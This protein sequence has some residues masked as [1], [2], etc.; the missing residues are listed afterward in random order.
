MK[1]VL[2]FLGSGVSLASGMPDVET[3]T[4]SVFNK[5]MRYGNDRYTEDAACAVYGEPDPPEVATVRSLI[6]KVQSVA[7]TY[8]DQ[9]TWDREVNYEDLFYICRQI[10]QCEK[11]ES[12]S[13]APLVAEIKESDEVDLLDAPSQDDR[14]D[15]QYT[16]LH[17]QLLIRGV[18]QTE[19]DD[20]QREVKGLDVIR[21]VIEDPEVRKTT[22]VTL[23]HDRLVERMLEGN[24]PDRWTCDYADG[25]GN[26]KGLAREYEAGNIF[27]SEESV[28]VIKP[29][30]SVDWF[31]AQKVF[32]DSDYQRLP[33]T[34]IKH[35]NPTKK[36]IRKLSN[37]QGTTFEITAPGPTFLTG[38]GKEQSYGADI[39]GDMI[40][41]MNAGLE[42]ADL[43]LVSG[44]GWKD[45][46]MSHRL[47]NA[48]EWNRERRMIL[49][50]SRDALRSDLLC[51]RA[52]Y[53][54]GTGKQYRRLYR[55]NQITTKIESFLSGTGWKE[56][57]QAVE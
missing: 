45:Q 51:N 32:G 41:A 21:Q 14:S 1:H 55:R 15:L 53:L 33:L 12:P 7:E 38:F 46:G 37:G 29:H 49:L 19:L 50:Y 25:F 44:F 30:G 5:P 27:N 13:I 17:A 3:L 11:G 18:V 16:A 48:L 28:R 23:N 52:S 34:Y 54:F 31:W 9:F 35:S 20:E 24:N 4:A 26:A 39:F 8:Y 6:E 36:H 47:L 56:I 57:K 22:I 40:Y 2:F 42:D 43:V 10:Y